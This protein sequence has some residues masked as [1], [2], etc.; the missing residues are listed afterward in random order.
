MTDQ[1]LAHVIFVSSQPSADKHLTRV[2]TRPID[3]Y[4]LEDATPGNAMAYLS[5]NLETLN[6]SP[7]DLQVCVQQI[8]GRLTDLEML[9]QKVLA[10]R[11]PLGNDVIL[12]LN[13]SY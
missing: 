1:R 10:G 12:L 3:T 11:T 5:Q 7:K 6:V 13:N 9:L 4:V 8:G 2:L